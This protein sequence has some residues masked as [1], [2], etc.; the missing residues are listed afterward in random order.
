MPN[1]G[2]I[3]ICML[4]LVVTASAEQTSVSRGKL[5]AGLRKAINATV[6]ASFRTGC[7]TPD[8]FERYTYSNKSSVETVESIYQLADFSWVV[9]RDAL[10]TADRR[11]GQ[12]FRGQLIITAS[13]YRRFEHGRWSEWRE[14]SEHE[15]FDISKNAGLP[16]TIKPDN[17]GLTYNRP[18]CDDVTRWLSKLKK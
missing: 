2:K 7:G 15:K 12:E 1:T 17:S 14:A 16:W 3:V 11:N 4:A 5:P 18:S 8:T 13:A 6:A 9:R 10:S